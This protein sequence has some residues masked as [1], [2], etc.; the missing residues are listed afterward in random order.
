MHGHQCCINNNRVMY[1]YDIMNN[2]AKI[3]CALLRFVIR[4][5]RVVE[6]KI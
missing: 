5:R 4:I 2:S 1:D 6:S 3:N